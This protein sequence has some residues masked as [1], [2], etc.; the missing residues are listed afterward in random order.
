MCHTVDKFYFNNYSGE[1]FRQIITIN[2]K[3]RQQKK[4]P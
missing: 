2:N 3:L 1:L 4:N